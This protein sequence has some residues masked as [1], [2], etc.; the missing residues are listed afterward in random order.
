[1][2]DNYEQIQQNY[3]EDDMDFS[4]DDFS[5]GV[6]HFS[7]EDVVEHKPGGNPKPRKPKNTVNSLP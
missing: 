2:A 3:Q 4:Q 1:M 7:Q 5:V 6:T